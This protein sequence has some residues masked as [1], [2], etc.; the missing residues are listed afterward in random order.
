MPKKIM[1][2]AGEASGDL[3]GAALLNA[4]KEIEPDLVTLGMGGE[5][6]REAGMRLLYDIS[7]LAFIGFGGVIRNMG[8]FIAVMR[9]LLLAVEKE[10]PDALVLIDYPGFNLRLAK[11]VRKMGIPIIYY[12]SPQVWAWGK[13]RAKKIARLVDK[14]LVIFPFEVDIYKKLGVDVEFVGHPLLDVLRA[15]TPPSGGHTLGLFP[16]SRSEEVR[17]HLPIM[18]ETAK[19]VQKKV[20]LQ[21]VLAQAETVD[22]GIVNAALKN[23]PTLGVTVRRNAAYEVMCQS[24]LILASS[25][26]STIECAC[27][28][29]P[30]VIIYKVSFLNWLLVKP[31]IKVSHIGM[32]NIMAGREIAPEFLQYR[33]SPSLIAVAIM[34]LIENQ[35]RRDKMIKDLRSVRESLGSPGASKRAARC[36][37]E[38][39]GGQYG[40]ESDIASDVTGASC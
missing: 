39:I 16:G 6:M 25:G 4:L 3:H 22:E 8:R 35:E 32:V 10:K 7:G 27:L 28:E 1:L 38:V 31:L 13:G 14:M 9:G 2:V 17:L 33:A 12:I 34:E 26:T 29:R 36:I 40:R 21:P 24:S 23:F 30:L 18:L 19:I 20:H 37:F 11:R 5:R 15:P